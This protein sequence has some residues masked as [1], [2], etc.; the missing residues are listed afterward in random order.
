MFYPIYAPNAPLLLTELT[1]LAGSLVLIGLA[2]FLLTVLLPLVPWAAGLDFFGEDS[3]ISSSTISSS[4]S[5]WL[6]FSLLIDLKSN[7]DLAEVFK[8]CFQVSLEDF[9]GVSLALA[10]SLGAESCDFEEWVDSSSLDSCSFS[11]DLVSSL[12]KIRPFFDEGSS[13]KALS[14]FEARESTMIFKGFGHFGNIL[15]LADFSNKVPNLGLDDSMVDF[16]F[17]ESLG[18]WFNKGSV[19]EEDLSFG[20][21]SLWAFIF[22]LIMSDFLEDC[23]REKRIRVSKRYDILSIARVLESKK[24]LKREMIMVVMV[25]AIR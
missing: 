5:I 19:L 6:D 24:E 1:W 12:I 9:N 2:H 11:E 10:A 16:V 7:C 20:F 8:G 13:E 4:L 3:F 14:H 18:P 17:E 25:Q 15:M 21:G 23:G 22:F